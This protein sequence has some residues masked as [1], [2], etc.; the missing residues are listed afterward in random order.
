MNID[1]VEGVS[2]LSRAEEKDIPKEERLNKAMS[3]GGVR[4]HFDPLI[5]LPK[6]QTN[7]LLPNLYMVFFSILFIYLFIYL[8]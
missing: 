3:N 6:K 2:L 4:M 5:F 7:Y 8:L 1:K